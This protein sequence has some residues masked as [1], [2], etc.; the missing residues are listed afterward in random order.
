MEIPVTTSRKQMIFSFE[1]HYG[2]GVD[3]ITEA[4][5]EQIA[6]FLEGKDKQL[7]G[8][9]IRGMCNTGLRAFL[10]YC[11]LRTTSKKKELILDDIDSML[12]REFVD[13]LKASGRGVNGQKRMYD[14]AKSVLHAMQMRGLLQGTDLFPHNP[15][16]HSRQSSRV[17][18]PYTFLE[19]RQI[20]TALNQAIRPLFS[21]GSIPSRENVAAAFLSVALRTGRNLTPL[22][23]MRTDALKPHFKEGMRLMVLTKRRSRRSSRL[24]VNTSFSQPET[25]SLL[26]GTV[27]IVERMLELTS[28]WRGD[29][30]PQLEERV[31]LFVDESTG[32]LDL[33]LPHMVHTTAED[34]AAEFDIRD[35][36]GNRLRVNSSRM[37]KTF[38][39]RI[40][41]ISGGDVL[42][43]ASAAG[44]SPRVAADNYLLP[45]R[46]AERRWRF[47]GHVLTNDLLLKSPTVSKTPSGSCRDAQQGH[48]APKDGG[49][50]TRFLDCFRCRDYVVTA[51]D[52]YKV[53]SVYWL[54]IGER[55]KIP[56]KHW[57]KY[58]AQVIRAVDRDIVEAGVDANLF[59][60]EQ[61]TEVKARA[62]ITPHPFWADRQSLAAAGA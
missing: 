17:V 35:D 54:L 45:D 4:C 28:P 30:D 46:Q 24:A 32:S 9:T 19:R 12:V 55:S 49:T 10:R 31:W 16:P 2:V 39:N 62:R 51:D 42:V 58:Y 36:D 56:Q 5:A 60:L 44:H 15:F 13:H 38:A 57:A 1:P 6:R 47:M 27:R 20:A 22:L 29:L 33:L 43:S 23:E 59:T 53:F 34:I 26:P 3:A 11:A 37:R 41:E 61:A 14:F 18:R 7:Q 25:A 52:L 48:F 8:D 50:C 21:A 40:F